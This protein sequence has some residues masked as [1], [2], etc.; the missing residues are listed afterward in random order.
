MANY[1]TSRSIEASLQDQLTTW[2]N[3]DW[4]GISVVKTFQQ[5]YGMSLPVI[6]VRLGDTTFVKGEI[7]NDN[8]IRTPQVFLDVFA[9]SDGQREDLVDYLV[10]KL[11]DGCPYYDYVTTTSGRTTSVTTKTQN[12]RIRVTQIN[13]TALNFNIEKSKTETHDRYR[14]LVTLTISLGRLE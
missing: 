12:G 2:I 10:S 7:G 9:T 3:A 13:T 8:L 14:G 6:C 5:V 4:T 11:K 1:R